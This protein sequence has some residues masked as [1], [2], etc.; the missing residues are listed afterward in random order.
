MRIGS[1]SLLV[2]ARRPTREMLDDPA[3][4]EAQMCESLEDLELVH[5]RWGGARAVVRY[6]APRLR[7]LER[8]GRVLD[9]G[10]GSGAFAEILG[11]ALA[12]EGV[13]VRV[14]ALDLQWRH[15][16]AGRRRQARRPPPAVGADGFRL[17]FGD[18]A[19]DFA[20]S[21]L[22]LHH[23]SPAGNRALLREFLRVA[24][25][26]FAILDLRRHLVPALALNVAGRLLF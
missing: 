17:P 4:P 5:R 11:E 3:L 13:E 25:E 21:S 18:D 14:I 22:F 15:L 7:D 1:M 16:A 20:V 24:R 12:A 23:F 9:I 2:P 6:L 19:F 26:G 8:R 10:A